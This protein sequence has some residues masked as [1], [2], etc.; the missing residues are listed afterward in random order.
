MAAARRSARVLDGVEVVLDPGTEPMPD[1]GVTDPEA[2]AWLRERLTPHPYAC[3]AQP[4]HL[5]HEAEVWKLPQT[6]I[7]CTS[8][9]ATRDPTRMAPAAAAGRVWDVDTGHDL[10]ITE[11][12][13]V[14]DL[15]LRVAE[16]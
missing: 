11:P 6:Q 16:I 3:F 13:A 15:L 8:T 5:D 7:V 1:Y 2:V 10:M 12:E 14:A 4:L 9:L